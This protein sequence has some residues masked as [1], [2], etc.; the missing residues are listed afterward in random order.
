MNYLKPARIYIENAVKE[1]RLTQ[2]AVDAFG[3]V[4]K[5]YIESSRSL[6]KA[7]AGEPLNISAPELLLFENKG[8]IVRTCPG[9][10]Y[11]TCCGYWVINSVINCNL[12][13]SYCILQSYVNN[14][15]ISITANMDELFQQLERLLGENKD[16]FFRIGTGE[17]SDS[18]AYDEILGVGEEL[19]NFFATKSN[20]IIELKTKTTNIDHLL[21]LEHKGNTVV[22]WSLNPESVI[23]K[24]E[25]LTRG[26]A[27][28]LEAAK[29]CADAGYYIGFH[30]DPIFYYP[31]WEMEYFQ[32]IDRTFSAIPPG[33]IAWVSLGAFRFMPDLKEII[34]RNYPDSNIIYGEFITGKD[35]KLRYFK[36][37]RVA[38]F[39]RIYERIK[40]YSEDIFIYL[41]MES[42]DVWERSFG[43]YLNPV[44]LARALDERVL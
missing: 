7:K 29:R 23:T 40:S 8:D 10:R 11:Y 24:E 3:S 13:C 42:R 43:H 41:C 18:L 28:R 15:L 37:I 26:L 35:G 32:V 25:R 1:S 34:A 16:R 21:G 38:L 30:F 20:G 12:G 19:V 17:L 33:R 36:P 4:P 9:T 22:S 5:E 2:R 6:I 39:K 14:P 27:Q 44:E 31:G